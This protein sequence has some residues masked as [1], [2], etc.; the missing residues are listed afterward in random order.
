[1]IDACQQEKGERI[2]IEENDSC[3]IERTE[4]K[5]MYIETVKFLFYWKYCVLLSVLDTDD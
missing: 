3:L 1:M 5:R 4:S 2:V